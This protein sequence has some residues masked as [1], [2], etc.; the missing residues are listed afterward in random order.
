[1]VDQM[2]SDDQYETVEIPMDLRYDPEFQNE[3]RELVT[4]RLTNEAADVFTEEALA[5]MRVL[6]VC[7]GQNGTSVRVEFPTER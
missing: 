4:D 6:N 7:M 5:K 3:L 1:M 2:A